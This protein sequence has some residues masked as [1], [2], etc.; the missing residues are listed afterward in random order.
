MQNLT[1]LL[2]SA[3]KMYAEEILNRSRPSEINAQQMVKFLTTFL[4]HNKFPG[5]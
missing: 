2:W 1:S 3:G 5:K 4:R